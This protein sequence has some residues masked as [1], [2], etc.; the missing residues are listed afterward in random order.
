MYDD[1]N[2]DANTQDL[3]V[4]F[5]K[6]IPMCLQY[7]QL[8][9]CHVFAGGAS[10]SN[11]QQPLNQ[12]ESVLNLSDSNETSDDNKQPLE[13]SAR[14][15]LHKRQKQIVVYPSLAKST[16]PQSSKACLAS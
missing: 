12:S 10:P 1:Q 3:N 6:L 7:N 4:T 9:P 14:S 11:S 15:S 2:I 13:S 16:S 8:D 5:E